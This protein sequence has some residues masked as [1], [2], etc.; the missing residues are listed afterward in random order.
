MTDKSPSTPAF[1]IGPSILTLAL[2]FLFAIP[3]WWQYFPEVGSRVV[4]GAPLWFVTSITGSITISVITARYLST[5][6][7]LLDA[8]EAEPQNGDGERQGADDE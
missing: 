5:A 3:W 2:L 6:W 8:A 4:L 1:P 7:K